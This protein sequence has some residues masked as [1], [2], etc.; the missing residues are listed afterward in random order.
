VSAPGSV[1][2][3]KCGLLAESDSVEVGNGQIDD[4]AGRFL[5]LTVGTDL[6]IHPAAKK[7][8]NKC[9]IV[10]I[11]IPLTTRCSADQKY[12]NPTHGFG[13]ANN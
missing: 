5:Q 12:I 7:D 11:R 4:V 9:T 2:L 1:E 8:K 3:N 13:T 10:S 6:F